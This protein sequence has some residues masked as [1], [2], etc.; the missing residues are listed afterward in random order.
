MRAVVQSCAA[1]SVHVVERRRESGGW[2]DCARI[3]IL[4]GVRV[5]TRR[6][7]PALGEK[8]RRAA[9]LEMRTEV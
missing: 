8:D 5:E 1:G 4:V 6:R 9:L 7:M 2:R 3:L